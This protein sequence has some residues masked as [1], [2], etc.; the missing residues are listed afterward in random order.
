MRKAL[1]FLLIFLLLLLAPTGL[2]Y[3]RFY[4]LGG[5]DRATPPA[6]EAANIAQVPTPVAADFVDEPDVGNGLVLL[7]Q[8][9]GNNFEL[10]EIAYLDGRLAARGFELLHYGGTDLS[11]ALR[12]VNAFIVIA[13]LE[14]FSPQ[15]VQAVVDFV[16]R[17]GRLLLVGDP[18]R[19]NF[20][21][22]EDD[23][24]LEDITLESDEIPLN[25]IANAFDIIYLGDYLYNT[26]ENEGNFRNIFLKRAGFAEDAM[27][28]GLDQLVF[29][30][31]HSLQVGP[32][33]ESLIMA[34][35]NTWSS[36]TD[37]PGDLTLAAVGGDGRVL[38]LGDLNFL[39]R[40][41]YTVFDNAQFIANIADFLV[42]PSERSY[43]LSDFPFFF[44]GSVD[45]VFAGAP[46]LGPDAFDE[47]IA[48]QEA[49]RQVDKS[50]QLVAAP[51]PDHDTLHFGLYNQAEELADV[52]AAH[53]IT[54]IIDPPILSV[55][56]QEALERKSAEDA[57]DESATDPAGETGKEGLDDE[58]EEQDRL[59]ASV[60]G[61]IRMSGT[62]LI[63]FDEHDGQRDVI[64]LAA[65]NDG[66]ENTVDRLLELIPLDAEYA[67]ADC[68][69]QDDL[70]LCPSN[71]VDEE[72]EAE[73]ETGGMAEPSEEEAV[74]EDEDG[75]EDADVETELDAAAQGS[76]GVGETVEGT[77][78]EDEAHAWV[79]GDGPA[80]IDIVVSASELDLVLEFYGPEY[81]LLESSDSEFSGDGESLLGI[82]VTDD[83]TYT[84][85]IS[86][87]FGES[88]D[89]TLS[90]TP[91]EEIGQNGG[92]IFLFADDDG[93][94][95]GDGS[96]SVELLADLLE[97]EYSVTTWYASTDGA[98]EEA[99]L[100][101]YE[102][103]IWDS[104]DYRDEAGSFDDDT[105]SILE[106]A[107]TGGPLLIMGAS[108]TITGDA[109]VSQLVDVQVVGDDPILLNGLVSGEVIELV[110][111]IDAVTSGLFDPDSEPNA[112]AFLSRG[113]ASAD[114]ESY[115]GVA[116]E[117]DGEVS[118]KTIL[119]LAPFAALPSEV[120][121]ILLSN[122]LDWFGLSDN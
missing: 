17:G 13:P 118:Q 77:L 10:E 84:I 89:Y 110:Q 62:A 61:S 1:I 113:P 70:A 66:L 98:L 121:A 14:R 35:D 115:V 79:F 97:G 20:I 56:E 114:N 42:E 112:I 11:T 69:L 5:E 119:F 87:F 95:L 21:V 27:V 96:T 43:V 106:Y 64:L 25:S 72:V 120:Q 8:G 4:D 80:I 2:R 44:S 73:L 41:Y 104:G 92:G 85:V 93:V 68:L 76:I 39:T 103:V 71:V 9:H 36:A 6:Y 31:S 48:L 81:E 105:F 65:S 94:P 24:F 63:I 54:L 82:E 34:D 29:Y 15:E 50:L 12:P 32:E 46:E 19:F 38:A 16:A 55:E 18:T 58:S 75:D 59:I 108:P 45:L 99:R 53:G 30:G 86:D 117:E 67:L 74:P 47:I 7:D 90:V 111:A 100:E 78:A 102:L 83:E 28:D 23:I 26:L 51:R 107:A 116:A 88:G 109:D 101:E 122:F 91:A 3:L 60:L 57:S 49:F 52:L 22:D 40:P 33:A 37:R